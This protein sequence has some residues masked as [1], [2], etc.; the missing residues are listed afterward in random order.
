MGISRVAFLNYTA[1]RYRFG[2]RGRLRRGPDFDQALP[3][4]QR[5]AANGLPSDAN[6]Y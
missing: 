4:L 6:I 3:N 2:N 1:R 5:R